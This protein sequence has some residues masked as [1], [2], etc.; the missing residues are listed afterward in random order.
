MIIVSCTPREWILHSCDRLNRTQPWFCRRMCLLG[1][2]RNVKLNT[3]AS[4]WRMTVRTLSRLARSSRFSRVLSVRLCR[5]VRGGYSMTLQTS[6][7]RISARWAFTLIELLVVIAIIAILIGLLLPAVQKV[8]EAANRIRCSNNLKQLGIALHN[9]HS[10]RG[11]LPPGGRLRNN[12]WVGHQNQGSWIL[13]SLPYLEQDN[14]YKLFEREIRDDGPGV[15]TIDRVPNWNKI[16]SPPF[17]R[18]PSDDFDHSITP[19]TNYVASIGPQCTVGPCGYNPYYNLCNGAL[20]GISW[21]PDNGST[22]DLY[23]T[24]GLFARGG[25][26]VRFQDVTDGTANTIM[27]GETR[28]LE[29]EDLYRFGQ[30]NWAT[31]YAPCNGSTLPPMNYRTDVQRYCDPPERSW[32]N[33]HLGFGF[34]SRH[35]QGCNFLFAD[36]SVVFLSQNIDHTLYQ[37]LGCR[38]DGQPA[39]IP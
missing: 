3:C 5:M 29:N 24:R 11:R 35:A 1:C 13:W 27:V 10:D 38:N 9:F 32:Q 22:G 4:I 14:V 20:P 21:S 34:K 25:A 23:Y 19:T 28:P 7:S 30:N 39:S 15:Y 8:R 17:L 37:Y 31:W 33:W 12:D 6:R 2:R 26:R 18:C 16:A 36:G